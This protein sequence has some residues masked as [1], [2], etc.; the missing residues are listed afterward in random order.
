ME[1]ITTR[2]GFETCEVD[3]VFSPDDLWFGSEANT[4]CAVIY[5]F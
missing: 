4:K 5:K 1:I 3:N 2:I